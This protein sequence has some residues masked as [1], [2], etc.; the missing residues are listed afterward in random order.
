MSGPA[1]IIGSTTTT[2]ETFG[3][4]GAINLTVSGGTGTLDYSWT[5]PGGFTSTSQDPSGL[6][7]NVR[8]DNYR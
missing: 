7:R 6:I 3:T 2:N 8:C 5:G 4:D 1:E